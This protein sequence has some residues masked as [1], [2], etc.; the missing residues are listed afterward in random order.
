MFFAVP[1][2]VFGADHF[3]DPAIVA[4]MV[5]SWIPWHLFWTYLV[6][7]ALIADA[8]SIVTN[9][10]PS[11]A[12]ALLSAVSFVCVALLHVPKLAANPSDR[13]PLAVLLRDLSFSAGALAF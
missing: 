13:I 1:M 9:K 7:T 11:L 2:A 5:P 8:L 3:I 10:S 6:G 4:A 12:A